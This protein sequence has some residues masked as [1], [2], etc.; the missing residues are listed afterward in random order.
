MSVERLD[1]R[2]RRLLQRQVGVQVDL[3]GLDRLVAKPERDHRAVDAGLEELH[4]RAVPKDVR[5]HPLAAER[6]PMR[7]DGGR[8]CARLELPTTNLGA[9]D[10]E[11]RLPSASRHE[12]HR[13]AHSHAGGREQAKEAMVGPAVDA[14][15]LTLAERPFEQPLELV[16]GVD[17]DFRSM[18]SQPR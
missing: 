13:L 10:V 16:L 5:R 3:G 11:H 12:A 17:V 14:P 1:L 9:T 6:D 7:V 15:C 8:L 2:Q 4:R 18:E